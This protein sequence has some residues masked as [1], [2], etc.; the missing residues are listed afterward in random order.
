MPKHENIIIDESQ[1]YFQSKFLFVEISIQTSFSSC[2][3]FWNDFV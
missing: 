3:H 2:Y 1:I